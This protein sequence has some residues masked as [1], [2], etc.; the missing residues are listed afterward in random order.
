MN[1]YLCDENEK[2]YTQCN[3]CHKVFC[4]ICLDIEKKLKS[5]IL[6]KN[7]ICI[8][9]RI[10]NYNALILFNQDQEDLKL[11]NQ[12]LSQLYYRLNET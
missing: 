11:K 7:N 3:N 6:N 10:K 2:E 5:P 8:F 1:C 12:N 4:K 9:C